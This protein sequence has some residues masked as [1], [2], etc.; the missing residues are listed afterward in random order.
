MPIEADEETS[1]DDVAMSLLLFFLVLTVVSSSASIFLLKQRTAV[2]PPNSKK[3]KKIYGDYDLAIHVD[4]EANIQV[5]A[6]GGKKKYE[7]GSE[8]NFRILASEAVDE[9]EIGYLYTET[10]SSS[11]DLKEKLE[12]YLGNVRDRLEKVGKPAKL[13]LSAAPTAPFGVVYA[14]RYGVYMLNKNVPRWLGMRL[15]PCPP[16]SKPDTLKKVL[17]FNQCIEGRKRVKSCES[18]VDMKKPKLKKRF[19]NLSKLIKG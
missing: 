12:V 4:A 17:Q 13:Y 6:I 14:I 3:T 1:F 19:C 10:T 9:E 7:E 5:L 16:L 11:V 15:V 18:K 2:P 8:G